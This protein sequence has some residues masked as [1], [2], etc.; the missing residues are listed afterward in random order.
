MSEEDTPKVDLTAWEDRLRAHKHSTEDELRKLREEL[1]GELNKAQ[2]MTKRDKEESRGILDDFRKFIEEARSKSAKE[3][4][5]RASKTTMV[6]PPDDTEIKQDASK[7][8]TPAPTASGTPPKKQSLWK[9]I[10]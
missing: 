2:E 1:L 3:E 5:A 7:E 6:T 10:W 9:K 8:G 4:E